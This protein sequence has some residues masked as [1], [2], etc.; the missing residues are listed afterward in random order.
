M[1][2]PSLLPPLIYPFLVSDVLLGYHWFDRSTILTLHPLWMIYAFT[3]FMIPILRLGILNLRLGRLFLERVRVKRWEAHKSFHLMITNTVVLFKR[4][5]V[6]TLTIVMPCI[7]KYCTG[8]MACTH[9]YIEIQR[10]CC[11]CVNVARLILS[12]GYDR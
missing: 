7:W 8:L 3:F 2:T 6:A 9:L 11:S 1:L 10:R 5:S 4:G 12:R